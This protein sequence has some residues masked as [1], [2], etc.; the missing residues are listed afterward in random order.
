MGCHL[1]ENAMKVSHRR[2]DSAKTVYRSA[3]FAMAIGAL[4][5]AAQGSD[6]TGA[7]WTGSSG[8]GKWED[9]GNWAVDPSGSV[10]TTPPGNS[11]INGARIGSASNT[12]ATGTFDSATMNW[13]VTN[14]GVAPGVAVN[15][16]SLVI[17]DGGGTMGTLNFNAGNL[18]VGSFYV[19][20]W[21]SQNSGYGTLVMSGGTIAIVGSLTV[22]NENGST[23]SHGT[24]LMSG[25]CIDYGSQTI[26]IGNRE[27]TGAVF[28]SGGSFNGSGVVTIGGSALGTGSTSVGVGSLNISGT[29]EFLSG[30]LQFNTGRPNKSVLNTLNDA[31]SISGG[32][33]SGGSI[34]QNAG[35]VNLTCTFS[36]TGGTVTANTFRMNLNQQGGTL[37]PG[38][39]GSENGGASVGSMT[40]LSDPNKQSGVGNYTEAAGAHLLLDV[41]NGTNDVV[42]LE[43]GGNLGFAMTATLNGEI[44]IN[45]DHGYAPSIGD[46]FNVLSADNIQ[47]SP[48]IRS[49]NDSNLI[50]TTN[51][52][53]GSIPEAPDGSIQNAGGSI[54]QVTYMGH[55]LPGDA[56]EDQTIDSS[57]FAVLAAHYGQT[58][59]AGWVEGDFN[60]DGTV[61]ALD[62]NALALNYGKGGTLEHLAGADSPQ[63]ELSMGLIVPEPISVIFIGIAGV[64]LM[65]NRPK[66]QAFR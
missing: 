35:S 40:L 11:T 17:G 26:G 42:R 22:G 64:L 7:Y 56:T 37:S 39:G 53:T 36:F 30:N 65:R 23:P 20:G 19:G 63:D 61:N 31:L 48:T 2:A 16:G 33:L 62:F 21:P 9:A 43:T 29:G 28:L 8:S 41:G 6:P 59:N 54:L 57:D 66:N 1:R 49:A 25:G 27:S 34:G 18:S 38:A 60:G 10:Q 51:K 12:A 46:T 4:S 24:I 47:G 14:G 50:F 3:V 55:A 32:T 5:S 52:I 44:D 13:Y 58:R 15:I 45:V